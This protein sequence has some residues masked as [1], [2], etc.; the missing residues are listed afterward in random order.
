MFYRPDCKWQRSLSRGVPPPYCGSVAAF[1]LPQRRSSK[2]QCRLVVRVAC[3]LSGARVGILPPVC[4]FI[5]SSTRQ[6]IMSTE[7]LMEIVRECPNLYGKSR[8]DNND[9]IK[10]T[11]YGTGSSLLIRSSPQHK[12]ICVTKVQSYCNYIRK[13]YCSTSAECDRNTKFCIYCLLV[14]LLMALYVR[15]EL[16]STCPLHHNEKIYRSLAEKRNGIAVPLVHCP[17]S[18]TAYRLLLSAP[19]EHDDK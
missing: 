5:P 6:T 16:R 8:A 2:E 17:V 19:Y 15:T 9:D 7:A 1:P 18:P 14:L 10:R 12:S 4:H 13:F 3:C 11:K